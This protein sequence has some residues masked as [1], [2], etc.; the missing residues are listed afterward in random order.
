MRC[1]PHTITTTETADPCP[2]ATLHGLFDNGTPAPGPGD[3][4]PP[5]GH[6]LALGLFGPDAG[7]A[8]LTHHTIV[9]IESDPCQ[10]GTSHA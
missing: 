2:V 6:W 1:E 8:D 10:E 7:A 3:A 5:L 9:T 4:L